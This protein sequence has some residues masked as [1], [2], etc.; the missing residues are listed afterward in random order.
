M[1]LPGHVPIHDASLPPFRNWLISAPVSAMIAAAAVCRIPGTL[2]ANSLAARN[3]AFACTC[4]ETREL[5]DLTQVCQPAGVVAVRLVAPQILHMLRIGQQNLQVSI[6]QNV[7][8]RPPVRSRALHDGVRTSPFLKPHSQALQVLVQRAESPYFFGRHGRRIAHHH[9]DIDEFPTDVD[10][11]TTFDHGWN[12]F[13]LLAVFGRKAYWVQVA[14]RAFAQ[15]RVRLPCAGSGSSSAGIASSPL[16]RSTLFL[17]R[18]QLASPR[19]SGQAPVFMIEG[20]RSPDMSG[21]SAAHKC[22]FTTPQPRL[23]GERLRAY[24]AAIN[25]RRRRGRSGGGHWRGA[26]GCICGAASW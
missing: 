4:W 2:C 23:E 13:L 20:V 12:H 24:R 1:L 18:F 7:V 19:R 10:P 5:R 16:R 6:V 15:F 17:R 25:A 26:L 8:N 21:S 9:A 14:L 22:L 3:P 11:R